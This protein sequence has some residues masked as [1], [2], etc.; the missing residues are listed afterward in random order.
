MSEWNNLAQINSSNIFFRRKQ[1][2]K[3]KKK[4]IFQSELNLTPA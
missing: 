4:S 3:E 1:Q 2:T